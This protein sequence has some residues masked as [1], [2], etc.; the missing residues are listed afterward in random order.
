MRDLLAAAL[1]QSA[2]DSAFALAA[3]VGDG[4]VSRFV[5][6]MNAKAAELGLDDTNYVRPDGLDA[7]GHISTARDTFRLARIAMDEPLVR[8]LV[9]K[10]TAEIPPGRK[11]RNWNDLLWTYPGLTGVKTGHTSQAGWAEVAAARRGPTQVYAVILGSPSRAKRNADLTQLLDWGFDQYARFPLVREGRR[12]ATA[13]VPFAEDEQLE[14]VA[15]DGASRLVRL[16]DGTR[17]VQQVIAPEM[18]ALPVR[19]G[20]KLGEVV[21]S[22]GNGEVARV[23]LVA[24]R[25]VSEPSFQERAGW[26]ADRALDEAGDMLAAVDPGALASSGMI[27]TVTLN[28]AIDRTLVV[29]NFQPGQ[30]HRASVGFPSA[31]GKGINVAR[32]LKRLGAPVVCTGLAGGRTGTLLVEELTHE[33]ILN[34]F[35]RIGA[36]SRTSIAVLDPTSNAYTEINEWGPEVTEEELEILREKLAYLAQ[37]AEFVVL[38]G[39]LPRA[40]DEGFYGE[41]VRELNRGQLLAV[42][43]AEGEPLRLALDAEPYL[44]SPNQREAEALVGHE[45][46]DHED[47][48]AGLDEIAALGARNVLITHEAGCYAL[49][50]EDRTRAPCARR[51]AAGR[52]DLGGRRGRHAPGRLPRGPG[53]R[54]AIRRGRARGGRRR[55]GLGA[56]GR[57]GTVRP[58]RGEP[59]RVT[60]PARAHRERSARALAAV[61]QSV[62]RPRRGSEPGTG[63]RARPAPSR[64]TPGTGRPSPPATASS[65]ATSLAGRCSPRRNGSVHSGTSSSAARCP[66]PIFR[67]RFV[68]QCGP[69]AR[70]FEKNPNDRRHG[71]SP[72]RL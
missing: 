52:S 54:E 20:Q 7:P 31:G 39:S 18:V 58:A 2:N 69:A 8:Q 70:A 14:L 37:R 55:S 53:R 16:G 22:D 25:A 34:D 61:G 19:Q 26:Y 45:F 66:L 3:E 68:F 56:R 59:P 41:L 27:V 32:A 60:R 35:V 10:R 65:R 62:S 36:E 21:V 40:V 6:M 63:R 49:L 24:A 9:R 48:A 43:D 15:A 4:S 30:R 29:P 42:V 1:I 64:A 28:T 71:F 33:G 38:A 57:R 72:P 67:P 17:F 51:G 12:Y 46:V 11:L 23:D 47:L 13:A 50:R 44:V 5:R